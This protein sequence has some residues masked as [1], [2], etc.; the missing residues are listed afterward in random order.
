MNGTLNL[1]LLATAFA[2]GTTAIV[3]PANATTLV[4]N[5]LV[6]GV[7]IQ[8]YFNGGAAS[9]GAI[10]PNDG[11]V[12]SPNAN[13]QRQGFNGNAPSGGT[14][15]FENNPSG[16]NGVLYFPFSS[17]TTSYLNDA[18]GFTSLSFGYSLL[19]NSSA[20]DDTVA[21]YSGLSGTGI[22][23]A[24][25][26]LTP[27]ST[28]VSCVGSPST[29]TS[30]ASAKD[31]FCTWSTASVSNFGVAQ[32]ILFGPTGSSNLQDIEF[33]DVQ[34]TP[35]PAAFPLFAT[36]LG[37]VGLLAWLRKRKAGSTVAA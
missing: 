10:G 21:V 18:S 8:N 33:D 31:E 2:I 5:Q 34:V 37:A 14:G 24:S 32:S 3:S 11:V 30:G 26:S 27:N 36:G 22:E 13:E 4:F 17:S 16:L 12:F 9:N 1:S 35:L 7:Q 20:F 29:S 25:L 19:N 23:L 28:A 6:N 15:K